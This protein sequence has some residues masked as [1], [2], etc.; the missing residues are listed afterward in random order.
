MSHGVCRNSAKTRYN[1][2]LKFKENSPS[3]SFHQL[4]LLNLYGCY[5]AFNIKKT[6]ALNQIE[7]FPFFQTA[8]LRNLQWA[9]MLSAAPTVCF[10]TQPTPQCHSIHSGSL[11]QNQWNLQQLTQLTQ[12]TKLMGKLYLWIWMTSPR[13]Q[14][15]LF[16]YA[17][18]ATQHKYPCWM[19]NEISEVETFLSPVKQWQ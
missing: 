11:P 12:L 3:S 18:F 7:P 8:I 13:P 17:F 19:E 10:F 16:N 9:S 2:L 4:S 1:L 15:S 5:L 14:T 6:D